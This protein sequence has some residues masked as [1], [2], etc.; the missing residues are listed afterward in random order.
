M[1][2]TLTTTKL[3]VIKFGTKNQ[4]PNFFCTNIEKCPNFLT[5]KF[6]ANEYFIFRA[7]SSKIVLLDYC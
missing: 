7:H 5:P 4:R 2:Y 1:Q 6:F 3:G